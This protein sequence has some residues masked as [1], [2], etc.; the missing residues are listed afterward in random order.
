MRKARIRLKEEAPDLHDATWG[1]APRAQRRWSDR[2]YWTPAGK[3]LVIRAW[4]R[5]DVLN[6]PGSSHVGRHPDFDPHR[7]Q[8]EGVDA[9][10]CPDGSIVRHVLSKEPGHRRIHFGREST[11]VVG[12]DMIDM[13]PVRTRQ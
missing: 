9:D 13:A 1:L 5:A 11:D 7:R 3:P 2:T 12:V 6:S 10:L 4:W 8:T